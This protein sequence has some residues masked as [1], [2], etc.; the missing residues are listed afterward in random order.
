MGK[1]RMVTEL[2]S[3]MRTEVEVERAQKEFDDSRIHIQISNASH[4]QFSNHS[5]AKLL[6][7]SPILITLED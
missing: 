4:G 6:K 2:S 7:N 5:A 3:I 1:R